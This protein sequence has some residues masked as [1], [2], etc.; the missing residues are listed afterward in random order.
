M[1]RHVGIRGRAEVLPLEK[2]R[3]YR[4]LSRYLGESEET[5]DETFRQE[6]IDR[7]DLII[8]I[9][10]TSLVARDQ[11]YFKQGQTLRGCNRTP[12]Q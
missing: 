3:L 8:R 11:S 1:L 5:W 7:L 6:V 2:D 12:M 10:P 4:L 9:N